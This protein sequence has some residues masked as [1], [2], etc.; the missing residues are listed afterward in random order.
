MTCVLNGYPRLAL[1]DANGVIPFVVKQGGDQMISLDSPK[2]FKVPP[3]GR[4]FVVIDKYRCD[5]GGLRGSRQIR[6]SSNTETSG[7]ASITFEDPH[8]VPMPYRIPDYCG[9]GD[10]GSTLTLSPFVGTFGAALRR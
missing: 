8:S 9:R 7:S 3:H 10:P 5:R 1:F 2:P 4:A 6:I